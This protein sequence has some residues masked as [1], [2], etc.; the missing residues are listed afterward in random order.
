MEIFNM[1]RASIEK[2]RLQPVIK[3]RKS[4]SSVKLLSDDNRFKAEISYWDIKIGTP[5]NKQVIS[6]SYNDMKE[7]RK[8]LR[9]AIGNGRICKRRI[10]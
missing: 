7:L 6:L 9:K 10:L 1:D 8:L 2:L 3:V 4:K 5:H